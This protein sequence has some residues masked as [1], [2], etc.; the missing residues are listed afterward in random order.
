MIDKSAL[1][2]MLARALLLAVAASVWFLYENFH[3]WQPDIFEEIELQYIVMAR[4]DTAGDTYIIDSGRSRIVKMDKDGRACYALGGESSG[5]VFENACEISVED[6]KS[7]FVHEIA[8]DE[9]GMSIAAERILEFD[10]VSG[11]LRR[12]VYRLDRDEIGLDW[13]LSALISLGGLK[14]EDGKLWFTRK[15]EN[16]F[17][18]YSLVPGEKAVGEYDVAYEDA[19]WTLSDVAADIAGKR[20]FFLDKAGVIRVADSG[21]IKVVFSPVSGVSVK[22][23]SR[24]YRLAFDGSGLYFADTGKRAILRLENYN[25]PENSN[26]AKIVIG[27][28]EETVM[29]VPYNFVHSRG[30]LL[31]LTSTASV[32]GISPE[33]EEFFRVSS[34]PAGFRIVLLRLGLW[35]SLFVVLF[36]L[37]RVFAAPSRFASVIEKAKGKNILLF[38]IL[39]GMGLA[40]AAIMPT[41]SSELTAASESEIMSHLYYIMEV[42]PKILD[43]EAFAEINTPQD[44]NGPAYRRFR[45]S[46]D[47]LLKRRNEWNKQ[48]FCDVFKFKDGLRYSVCFLDGT[49]GAFFDPKDLTSSDI[50]II[51]NGEWIKNLDEHDVSGNYISLSGPLYDAGGGV[52]GG[53][54]IGVDLSAL[55]DHMRTLSKNAMVHTLLLLA[56]LF[57]FVSEMLECLPAEKTRV[58]NDNEYDN[59]TDIPVG[60]LRLI[61]FLVFLAFNLFAGFLPNYAL[62]IG[63]S[64]LGFSPRTSAVF[65]V[66][67]DGVCLALAPLILPFLHARLGRRRSFLAGFA[68]CAAGYALSALAES[69]GPLIAGVG[70][71]SLGAGILFTLA[72][73]CAASRKDPDVKAFAFSSLASAS[74]SGINCGIMTGGIVAAHFSQKSVFVFGKF[75]S[76]FAMVV[77]LFLTRKMT[78]DWNRIGVGAEKSVRVPIVFPRGIIAF[79]V[80]SFFPF[81]LYG[82]FMYYLVPVFGNQAGFSDT[83]ISLI[84]VLF[85]VGIM[86]LAPGIAAFQRREK[87]GKNTISYFLRL[88]LAV[89]LAGILCFAFFQSVAA[90]LAAVFILGGASGIGNTYFPLYLTEMPETKKLREGSDMAL[91]N[92][93]ENLGFAA[94]PMV[95]SAILHS[96]AS[97]WYYVLAASMLLAFLSYH[98]VRRE[99][100]PH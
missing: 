55:E 42:S 12:E 21:G 54:E 7:F 4:T 66:V 63:G 26:A 100:V 92:F 94:G 24:P 59:D 79:L 91:F 40:L 62:S 73:M 35:V 53:I 98:A 99:A 36:S 5:G 89:E 33:G 15:N 2:R 84:F 25:N 37:S 76:I 65:P 39:V 68:L 67:A 82:G 38:S 80:L 49:I 31:T 60:H 72:Q 61:T 17:T 74:F 69:L 97:F 87:E 8:W 93:I 10:K 83:E 19:L 58:E 30:D 32:V 14:F 95:F 11:A 29:P 85:G 34:L 57:F 1:R 81:T 78:D 44:Y 20:I 28:W 18:L 50:R 64:F 23:I 3:H 86:F 27:G 41:F 13:K 70:A 43:L 77:F 6:K 96:G 51:E 47:N 16:S 9:S 90:M 48:I 52:G 56:L 22:E 88:A 46:L 71:L 75:L 45:L